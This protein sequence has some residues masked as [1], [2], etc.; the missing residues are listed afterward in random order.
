MLGKGATALQHF[1]TAAAAAA[2]AAAGELISRLLAAASSS[3]SWDE[4]AS[5][6]T[7]VIL[8]R[9]HLSSLHFNPTPRIRFSLLWLAGRQTLQNLTCWLFET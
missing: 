9:L 4:A 5:W 1:D 6:P 3:S 2:A 7:T 8:P